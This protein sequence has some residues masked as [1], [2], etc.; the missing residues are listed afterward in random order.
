MGRYRKR[1]VVIDAVQIGPST[2]PAVLDLLQAEP[3]AVFDWQVTGRADVQI[4]VRTLEGDML[5]R[6]GD[7]LIRGVAGE[8]YPCRADIFAAT[9]EEATDE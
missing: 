6:T 9:Y 7:W 1:P 8:V 3:R 4:T 2:W 5:A